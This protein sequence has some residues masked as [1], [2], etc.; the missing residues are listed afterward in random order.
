MKP[1]RFFLL[2]TTISFTI[3]AGCGL[4][5]T[6]SSRNNSTNSN[7]NNG[8]TNTVSAP[9]F[10]PASDTYASAIVVTI[11]SDTS[12]AD[13]YYA[14]DGSTPSCSGTKYT[15]SIPVASGSKTI[16]AIACKSGM[17]SS[18][19]IS[20][21][22]TI[23]SSSTNIAPPAFSPDGGSYSTP[24][25]VTISA[26]TSGSVIHYT[27]DSAPPADPDCSSTIYSSAIN[28]GA[29]STKAIKAIACNAAGYKSPISSATYIIDSNGNTCGTL[30]Q[31][32]CPIPSTVPSIIGCNDH[33]TLYCDK[34]NNVYTC[35]AKLGEGATCISAIQCLD[36]RDACTVVMGRRQCYYE[37]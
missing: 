10:S 3:I 7:L 35:Q 12:G 15:N 6:G 18:E 22:Y 14:T 24:Q 27:I 29:G 26:S 28:I 16:K 4:F 34:I 31:A 17:D 36:P 21:T 25:A 33:T 1:S 8:N 9:L 37:E 19:I 13:I 5:G 20:A 11:S 30:Y 32:C 2:I 23:S